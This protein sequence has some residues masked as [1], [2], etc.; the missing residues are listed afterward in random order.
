MNDV[1]HSLTKIQ[2]YPKMVTKNPLTQLTLNDY[3][4][5][6]GRTHSAK[7]RQK[8]FHK[9]TKLKLRLCEKW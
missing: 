5:D 8:W 7:I 6:G 9:I 4:A 1:N 2:A 3:G